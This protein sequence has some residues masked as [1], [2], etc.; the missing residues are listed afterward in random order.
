MTGEITF[1]KKIKL[2]VLKRKSLDENIYLVKKYHKIFLFH[3][4]SEELISICQKKIKVVKAGGGIV[5]NI[6]DETLFI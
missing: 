3:K 5:K 2:Y 4:N 6:N 1:G